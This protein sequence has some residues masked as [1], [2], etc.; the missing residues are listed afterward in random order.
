MSGQLHLSFYN[1]GDGCAGRV[2]DP[3]ICLCAPPP[4]GR[5]VRCGLGSPTWP[6]DGQEQRETRT[7]QPIILDNQRAL[8]STGHQQSRPR[9]P[10]AVTASCP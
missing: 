8:P 10:L 7:F 5:P 6:G 2:T 9:W 1:S 3:P 4:A